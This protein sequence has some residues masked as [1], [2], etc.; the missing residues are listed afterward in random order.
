[1]IKA[2]A[3]ALFLALPVSALYSVHY[4]A[5]SEH[6]Q[7]VGKQGFFNNAPE[8]MHVADM[9]ARLSGYSPLLSE[10]FFYNIESFA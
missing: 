1:M 5:G 3:A 2:C 7:L 9:Y 6:P 8:P 4:V 10:G